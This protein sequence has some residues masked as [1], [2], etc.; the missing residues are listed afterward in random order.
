MTHRLQTV[1]FALFLVAIVIA[2]INKDFALAALIG[3][4]MALISPHSLQK[5]LEGLA[6]A[7]NVDPAQIKQ[8]RRANPGMTIAEA[9]ARL[10]EK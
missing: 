7:K 4:G 8:L 10:S 5:D 9:A 1:G 3:L 6:K 2:F